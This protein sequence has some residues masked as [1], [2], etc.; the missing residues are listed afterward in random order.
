MDPQPG[1]SPAVTAI[2]LWRCFA[3]EYRQEGAAMATPTQGQT[4]RRFAAILATRMWRREFI[5]FLAGA[6]VSRPI[7]A[8]AQVPTKRPL[9]AVLSAVSQA[10]STSAFAQRLQELGYVKGRD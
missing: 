4:E 7:I 8:V 6:A 10:V 3:V 2:P 9:I 5:A 1:H